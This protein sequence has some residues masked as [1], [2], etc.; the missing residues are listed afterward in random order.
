[1]SAVEQVYF[2]GKTN[3]ENWERNNF[4]KTCCRN[5]GYILPDHTAGNVKEDAIKQYLSDVEGQNPIHTILKEEG[6]LG[7]LYLGSR[8][9]VCDSEI[10]KKNIKHLAQTAGGL[11]KF[12]PPWGKRLDKYES[13]GTLTIFRLGWIDE[14]A[15]NIL[16]NV[17][18]GVK[19]IHEG[20]KKGEGV[21]V[22]CAQGKSRSGTMVIAYLMAH[23]G[24][25]AE[26]ACKMVQKIRSIVQP[27]PGFMS[28]L[29]EFE[30]SDELQELRKE[31]GA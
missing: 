2:A 10:K 20:R 14:P 30:K 24:M 9:A 29:E 8:A 18:E 12:Y 28:Q 4:K 27:N 6:G 11:E 25:T 1:M 3:C 23:K 21:L 5:C 16:T 26:A 15:Q 19:F 31:I 22:N 13:D 7:G 17:G